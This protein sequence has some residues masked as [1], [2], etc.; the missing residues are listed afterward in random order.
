MGEKVFKYDFNE[1]CFLNMS[2]LMKK[3][4]QICLFFV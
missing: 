1:A 2:F 3:A 4:F